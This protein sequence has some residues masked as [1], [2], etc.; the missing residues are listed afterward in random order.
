MGQIAY[1]VEL[2]QLSNL[3]HAHH[4]DSLVHAT[5]FCAHIPLTSC[6]EL[7]NI[8]HP[9]YKSALLAWLIKCANYLIGYSLTNQCMVHWKL[10]DMYS[11][12]HTF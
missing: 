5:R 12:M 1:W 3:W 11:S 6:C 9:H 2:N 4:G 8:L 7:S 10:R